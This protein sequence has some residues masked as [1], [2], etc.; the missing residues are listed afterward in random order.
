MISRNYI[1]AIASLVGATVGVGMFTL[2]YASIQAGIL[3]VLG[4]F[5]VLG[6]MQ[7]WLHKIYAE[8]VLSTKER[9]RLPGYAEKYIGPSSKKIIVVLVTV[10]SYG[11]LLAY[12]IIGG[13]FL[14]Q[15][16]SPYFGG[17]VFIY[18]TLLLVLR[19]IIV[20]FGLRWITRAEVVL[21]A[22]L[23]GAIMIVASLT[24]GNGSFEN[25]TLF[26]A[27]HAI[28]PYGPVFFAISGIIAVNDICIIL[29]NDKKRI[30]SALFWGILI[31]ILIMITFTVLVAS[32]SGAAT[33]ADA[34]SGLKN[35]VSLPIYSALLL[36]GVIAI[37]TVYLA[38]AEAL[39]EVY[40][41]DLKLPR[42]VAWGL[43][44]I[45]PY[46]LYLLGAQDLT[47]VIAITGAVIGGLLG[48]LTLT[49]A[50]YVK[51]KPEQKSPLKSYLTPRLAHA[52]TLLFVFGLL[53]ELWEIFG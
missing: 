44:A 28:L 47:K 4:F 11:S 18:T 17:T 12:T 10:A 39:E 48:A 52:L 24:A 46:L 20:L 35:F 8:I 7:H 26:N 2:P 51:K 14:F 43:V 31:S 33:T 3:T 38:M 19:S 9:H 41:W 42:T 1:A 13:D 22:G 15:L 40:M 16:L 23:V 34:L 50:I 32:L 29:K 30:K 45:V 25:L 36:I 21:T 37:T 27:S 53:Y 5:V 6:V 49:I